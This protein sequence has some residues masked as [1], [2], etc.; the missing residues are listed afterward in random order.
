MAVFK[1]ENKARPRFEFQLDGEGEVYS[2]P[3]LSNL[4]LEQMGIFQRMSGGGAEAF[5][6]IINFFESECPGITSKLT[7]EGATALFNAWKAWEKD[8]GIE[9]GE[10]SA[11]NSSSGPTEQQ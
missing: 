2:L 3:S 6:E 11:S 9:L 10:S 5:D 8:S 1:I 7:S 4:S